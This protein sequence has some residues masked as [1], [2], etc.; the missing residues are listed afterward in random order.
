M[1][2]GMLTVSDLNVLLNRAQDHGERHGCGAWASPFFYGVTGNKFCQVLAALNLAWMEARSLHGLETMAAGLRCFKSRNSAPNPAD[3]PQMA[4]AM[5]APM[6]A[7]TTRVIAST[8][9]VPVE[10]TMRPPPIVTRTAQASVNFVRRMRAI[11]SGDSPRTQK[12]CPSRL[13]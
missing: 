1:K 5:H 9:N 4:T 7:H 12:L 8:R 2:P 11:E 3:I 10:I 13:I 6:N